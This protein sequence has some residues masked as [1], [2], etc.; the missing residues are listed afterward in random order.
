MDFQPD[1]VLD[2]RFF[3]A[4]G[5]AMVLGTLMACAITLTLA[6][7]MADLQSEQILAHTTAIDV[8]AS[9]KTEETGG[10]IRE[11]ALDMNLERIGFENP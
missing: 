10:Q 5:F 4:T 3:R 2:Y 7:N 6:F 11:V 8:S 1:Q 9:M